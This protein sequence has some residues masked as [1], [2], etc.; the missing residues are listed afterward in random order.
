MDSHCNG[1]SLVFL[2]TTLTILTSSCLGVGLLLDIMSLP[3][4]QVTHVY[5]TIIIDNIKCILYRYNVT[6]Y[7]MVYVTKTNALDSLG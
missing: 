5:I 2:D 7:N 4:S 6:E 1:V 3:V